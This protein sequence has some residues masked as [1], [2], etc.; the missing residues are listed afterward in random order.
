M[1]RMHGPLALG[2]VILM[3]TVGTTFSACVSVPTRPGF[4]L[5]TT[6]GGNICAGVNAD[7]LILHGKLADGIA[8]VWAND[9][10]AIYWPAGYRATFDP[11]LVIVDGDGVTRGREGEEMAGTDPW[12]GQLI[13]PQYSIVGDV[14]GPLIVTIT[15]PNPPLPTPEGSR[16]C[17][18]VMAEL[19]ESLPLLRADL[20]AMVGGA[21]DDETR[22]KLAT[23]AAHARDALN[24][25]ADCYEQTTLDLWAANLDYLASP[26]HTGFTHAGAAERLDVLQ[27]A[28]LR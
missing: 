16:P 17:P 24:R 25:H 18:E 26:H 12:H 10:T 14:F 3:I 9:D 1:G 7:S 2:L 13:C 4:P 28:P 6:G 19:V 15:L 21:T 22:G 20:N 11:S 5:P 23:D 27:G 8:E